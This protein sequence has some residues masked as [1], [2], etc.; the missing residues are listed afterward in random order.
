MKKHEFHKYCWLFGDQLASHNN[1]EMITYTLDHSV[2]CWL[3]PANCS[4][5]LQPLK[6]T[7]FARFIQDIAVSKVFCDNRNRINS[8]HLNRLSANTSLMQGD[9]G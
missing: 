9:S 1:P 7:A 3:F 4:H 5:F 2:M 6:A 8:I